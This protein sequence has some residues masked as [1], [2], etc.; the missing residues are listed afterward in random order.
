M[1][2]LKKELTLS[3]LFLWLSAL[4]G[5]A[6]YKAPTGKY[7]VAYV[8]S[9]T[10]DVPD[11]MMVDC[12]NFAFAQISES[13]DSVE[14]ENVSRLRGLLDLKLS[15]PRLKVVLS[16]G[17]WGGGRFSELA[18]D[19][20]RRKAFSWYCRKLIWNMGIDGIDI[21]W[22]YPTQNESGISA[23]P[24]DTKNFTLLLKDLRTIIGPKRIISVATIS[25]A[26]Y[27]DF[28]NVLKYVDYF[29]VM[30][31]DMGL[32]PYHNSPLYNSEKVQNLSVSEAVE[33]HLRAGVPREKIVLGIPF[34]GRGIE[35]FPQVK[36]TEARLVSNYFY[37]WDDDA[38]VPYLTDKAGTLA[39][40][41][42]DTMSI[43][44]KCDFI[45]EQGLKGAMCWP[46]SCDDEKGTLLRAVYQDL[47]YKS[48]NK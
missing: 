9:W 38:K 1:R 17:G 7:V 20:A 37:N 10:D 6:Q 39:Y 28:R 18:A 5:Y 2:V 46:N 32:P 8:T 11:P 43:R 45:Q 27:I 30:T 19:A 41:Y 4:G 22:E 33:D 34:Y 14:I 3:I 26:K 16:I 25:S 24:D 35:G 40:S 21:D 31:Y 47:R 12:I 48:D 36:N 29:N 42:D 15:N 44:Y 13:F 23:S